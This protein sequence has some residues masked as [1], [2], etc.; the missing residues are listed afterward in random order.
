MSALDDVEVW[1]VVGD[2]LT[3]SLM[4]VPLEYYNYG[5]SFPPPQGRKAPLFM[6]RPLLGEDYSSFTATNILR[7][8]QGFEPITIRDNIEH[9]RAVRRERSRNRSYMLN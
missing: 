9:R 8:S 4:V 7:E 1:S 3:D 2:E 5:D 6:Y